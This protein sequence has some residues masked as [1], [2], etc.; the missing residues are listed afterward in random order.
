MN[1]RALVKSVGCAVIHATGMDRVVGAALG[2]SSQPLVLCYHR[3][4]P[5]TRRNRPKANAPSMIVTVPTLEAQLDA[6]GRTYRFVDLDEL[7]AGLASGRPFSRPVASVTFDDGYADSYHHAWPC[8]KRK[9]IPTAL[10][11]PTAFVGTERLMPH[12]AVH[13]LLQAASRCPERAGLGPLLARRGIPLQPAESLTE[14]VMTALC[15][16]EVGE[17][18]ADLE[19]RVTPDPELKADL[20]HLTWPMLRELAGAGVVIGSHSHGHRVLQNE[21]R[22]AIVEELVGSRRILETQLG[23]EVTHFAFP[24][25]RYC[26]VSMEAALDAGYRH[27]YTT[28]AHRYSG[29]APVVVPRRVF[30]ERSSTGVNAAVSPAVVAC[31]V[32]GVFDLAA[33]CRVDH[34]TRRP[35]QSWAGR[36]EMTGSMT[37]SGRLRAVRALEGSQ[38]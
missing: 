8:L 26:P 20:A 6:L 5:A 32:R 34:R 23:R 37:R 30:W 19:A 16:D 21:P 22:S 7:A 10:F 1:A 28:C 9:G 24:A 25:G 4:L 2:H 13:L 12:D 17:L 33:P 36:T 31:Q 18:V 14:R 27:V 11:V 29:R 15:L 35:A 38:S 3:V